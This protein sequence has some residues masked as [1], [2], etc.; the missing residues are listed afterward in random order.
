MREQ[1]LMVDDDLNVLEAYKRSLHG[2]FN[3]VV[4]RGAEHA[5]LALRTV[6]F[7]AV[8]TDFRMPGKNG[9]SV[10]E[11]VRTLQ[12]TATRIVISGYADVLEMSDLFAELQ[13]FQVLIKPCDT[14]QLIA[15][16]D[17]ALERYRL[18]E[19]RSAIAML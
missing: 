17:A 8:L 18:T 3:V 12:P 9:L 5:Q 11:T 13:V 16:L 19:T 6:R 10:L 14:E 1:I 15:T 2:K 4:A 7:A